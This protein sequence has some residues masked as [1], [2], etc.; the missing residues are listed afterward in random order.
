ML[1]IVISKMGFQI[2]ATIVL[3]TLL[4]KYIILQRYSK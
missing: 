4:E 3:Y 2:G 1:K